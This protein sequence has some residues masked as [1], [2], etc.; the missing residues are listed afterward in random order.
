[1][2]GSHSAGD[3][4]GARA[5]LGFRLSEP[6][7][8][9]K[10][11]KN[12]IH[13]K[14]C[15]LE[16]RKRCQSD[17]QDQR[18]SSQ[19]Q[20]TS[21]QQQRSSQVQRTKSQ[22]QRSGREQ[23]RGSRDHG[24]NVVKEQGRG[25]QQQGRRDYEKQDR[26]NQ[27]QQKGNGFKGQRRYSQEE[28]DNKSEEEIDSGGLE[29]VRT[30]RDSSSPM[31]WDP[32]F[33]GEGGRAHGGARLKQYSE[34]NSLLVRRQSLSSQTSA[35]QQDHCDSIFSADLSR[36]YSYFLDF[37]DD[38]CK[39]ASSQPGRGVV[40]D[41][42]L[43]RVPPTSTRLCNR[44]TI[45]GSWGAVKPQLMLASELLWPTRQCS[46]HPEVGLQ[47]TARYP[48]LGHT[49]FLLLHSCPSQPR[50]VWDSQELWYRF[51]QL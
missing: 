37:I 24:K 51:L 45:P 19:V 28:E 12:F 18:S 41:S 23:R 3:P 2:R 11:E 9:E 5:K 27:R 6:Y 10:A 31:W 49:P 36:R 34:I 35:A 21:S 26:N 22:E 38:M 16:Q 48:A 30:R 25:N 14:S 33:G 43:Q 13:V 42:T 20:R 1:M 46:L 44:P 8:N 4:E 29:Y 40:Q 32:Q 50:P 15:R 39:G 7:I 17:S 47:C